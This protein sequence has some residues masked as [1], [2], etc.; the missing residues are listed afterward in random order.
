MHLRSFYHKYKHW[1]PSLFLMPVCI[2]L[3]AHRHSFTI[4]DNFNLLIHEGGHGI[5]YFFP[6]FIYIAGGTIMQIFI[7]SLLAWYFFHNS[8]PF[9]F[10]LGLLWLGQNFINI[11]IYASDAQSRVLPLLG[12][13]GVIHD[14]HYLLHTVG[15]LRYDYLVGHVFFGIAVIIF[16][17]VILVPKF[18][19]DHH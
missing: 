11:S 14:W 6:K 13:G 10:Q 19:P 18:F 16:I 17:I 9:G 4:I 8:Y 2:Y 12:G 7:P 3:I 1:F 15:I 5:F